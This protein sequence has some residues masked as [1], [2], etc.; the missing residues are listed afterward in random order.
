MHGEILKFFL[1]EFLA[2]QLVH[3]CLTTCGIRSPFTIFALPCQ[4]I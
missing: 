4:Q 3:T 1:K 2:P